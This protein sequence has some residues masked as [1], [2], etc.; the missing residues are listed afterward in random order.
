M[1]NKPFLNYGDVNSASIQTGGENL[2]LFGGI[3]NMPIINY[4]TIKEMV[5]IAQP[6]NLLKTKLQ[7]FTW[8]IMVWI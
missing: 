4:N 8:S 3:N 1:L 2:E 7:I 6:S 5:H